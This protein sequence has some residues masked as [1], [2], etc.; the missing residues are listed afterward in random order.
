MTDKVTFSIPDLAAFL[1]DLED[2]PKQVRMRIVKGAV[3]TGASVIRKESVLRAP[4]Y[5]GTV[6]K[7]HPQPGTLKK[8]IYQTRLVDKCNDTTEVWKVDV[9]KGKV[10][11]KKGRRMPDAYYA[12][13]VE[14][15]HYT[16]TPGGVGTR[17]QRRLKA[18]SAGDVRWV[19]AQPFMR[20][21]FEAKKQDAFQA[22]VD[23]IRRELASALLAQRFVK[24][25]A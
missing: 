24:L 8:S 10:F 23:Y 18:R 17:A 13:W 25:A 11:T 3:A 16:R 20:P 15:G 21:A 4:M 12:A 2:L 22:M 5:P 14:Y 6:G 9:R 7:D 1:R 19:P